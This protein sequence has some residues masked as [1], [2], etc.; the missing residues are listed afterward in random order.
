MNKNTET[1]QVAN[2]LRGDG[3]RASF[4]YLHDNHTHT[5]LIGTSLDEIRTHADKV[6]ANHSYGMLCP[7]IL[8]EGSQ[9]IRRVGASAHSGSAEC[10]KEVWNAGK[11]KWRAEVEADPDIRRL[12]PVETSVDSLLSRKG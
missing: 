2:H 11:A 6:E 9:G 3:L 8:L 5:R 7:V 1:T 12:F 10:S 4:I